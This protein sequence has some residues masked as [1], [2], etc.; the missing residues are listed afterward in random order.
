MHSVK[1]KINE[2]INVIVMGAVPKKPKNWRFR[3]I[4]VCDVHTSRIP[5]ALR[6]STRDLGSL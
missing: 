3:G 6:L 1:F 2:G 5:D 4:S